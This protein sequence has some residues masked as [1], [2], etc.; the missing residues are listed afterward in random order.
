M[1]DLKLD[2]NHDLVVSQGD[3]VL[4]SGKEAHAQRLKQRLLL[5]FGEWFLDRLRGIPIFDQVFVKR[6]NPVVVDALY[7][8]EILLDPSV[9]ELLKFE[10]D[11]DSSTRNLTLTFEARTKEGNIVFDEN[12]TSR[13]LEGE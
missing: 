7:K 8:R 2:G 3:L 4:T 5:I 11:I 12:F 6:P 10:L 1:S 13:Q 9:L